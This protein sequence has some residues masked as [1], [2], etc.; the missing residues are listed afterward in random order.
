MELF[1]KYWELITG[2]LAGLSGLVWGYKQKRTD[3][4]SS[5]QRI[6]EELIKDVNNR[7]ADMKTEMDSMKLDLDRLHKENVELKRINEELRIENNRL[8]SR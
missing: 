3:N 1:A 6:Y 7:M 8:K 2:A 4:L 5:I